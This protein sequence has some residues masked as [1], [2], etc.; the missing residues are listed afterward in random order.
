MAASRPFLI[1]AALLLAAPAPAAD[2]ARGTIGRYDPE[3]KELQLNERPV[4]GRPPLTFSLPPDV[5]ILKG[6]R[7]A[8]L[9]DL[10]PGQRVRV[11]YEARDGQLVAKAVHLLGAAPAERPQPEMKGDEL[12]GALRRVALTDREIVIIG[13]GAK[14]ADTE[15][16]VAV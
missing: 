2:N 11:E 13:P 16:T 15:T 3:K 8:T 10:L 6:R 5:P 4:L 9:A 12:R 1:L 7:A 14:G